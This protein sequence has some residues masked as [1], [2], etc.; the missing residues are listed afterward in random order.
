[1]WGDI[2]QILYFMKKSCDHFKIEFDRQVTL[3]KDN[4]PKKGFFDKLKGMF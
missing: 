4:P 2:D 1:M 3:A